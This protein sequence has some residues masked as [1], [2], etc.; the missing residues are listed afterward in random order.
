MKFPTIIT[1]ALLGGAWLME[2]RQQTH[3]AQL[4]RTLARL[5]PE[6]RMPGPRPGSESSPHSGH[7]RAAR[8]SQENPSVVAGHFISQLA[9][10]FKKARELESAG[11]SPD[12]AE[13]A[14]IIY[15]FSKL[16]S[17]QLA[18]LIGQLA[19]SGELDQNLRSFI[20]TMSLEM[21]AADHPAMAWELFQQRAAWLDP[22]SGSNHPSPV[23]SKLL[24]L[25]ARDHPAAAL[26]ALKQHRLDDFQHP[27]FAKVLATIA[28]SDMPLALHQARLA[29][30][31]I[32]DSELLGQFSKHLVSTPAKLALLQELRRLPDTGA[33]ME[34]LMISSISTGFET[35]QEW[36]NPAM[37]SARETETL[38]SCIGSARTRDPDRWLEWLDRQASPASTAAAAKLMAS[39]TALDTRAAIQWAQNAPQGP[40]G[41]AAVISCVKTLSQQRPD[42]ARQ[43][44]ASL[45]APLRAS[46]ESALATH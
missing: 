14:S 37:L 30:P 41:E 26:A 45:P 22:E 28:E 32:D 38:I 10:F 40:I 9:V 1:L 2:S 12:P 18:E 39:W 29:L 33:G 27:L 13:L 16:N 34:Q 25:L 17:G 23:L 36:I 24:P 4:Q 5:E 46:A 44:L 21:L 3:R 11:K 43:L 31:G 35:T 8:N 7:A 20:A 19:D 15:G 42:E 6:S